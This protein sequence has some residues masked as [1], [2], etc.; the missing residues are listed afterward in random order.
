MFARVKKAGQH[1][2]L[3]RVQNRREGAKTVQRIVAT[4]GRVDQLQYQGEIKRMVRSLSR[5]SEK[6][7][8]I[9]SGKSD[10]HAAVKKI[11][12]NLIFAALQEII[13][14]DGGKTFAVRRECLGPCG[15]VFQAVGVAFPPTIIEVA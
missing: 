15:K 9:L 1:Q 4:I 8:L 11:G 2:H 3:Q 13:L 6:V 14:E 12:P 5:F 10:V 7:L